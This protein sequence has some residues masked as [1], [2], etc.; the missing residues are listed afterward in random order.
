MSEEIYNKCDVFEGLEVTADG[1]FRLNG[2]QRKAIYSNKP[3]GNHRTTVQFRINHNGKTHYWQAAKLVAQAWKPSYDIDKDYIIYKD[4]DCQNIHADNL[5]IVSYRDYW[6]YLQRNSGYKADDVEKRIKKLR[7]VA[8][9]AMLTCNYFETLDMTEINK[10]VTSYLYKCLMEYS[11]ETL[12]LGKST[13]RCIVPD[14]LARMYEVIM[15]GMCLYNYERYCKKLLLNY[16]KKGNFGLTGKI[17]KPI[18]INIQQLNLD[19]LWDKFNV[20][21]QK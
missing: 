14:C 6:K 5:Q 12:H 7:L 9:E 21:K 4:G 8:E 3:Y 1:K 15:N 10:H 17:P 2:K 18:Q 13:A 11:L 20:K 19:C 16:K